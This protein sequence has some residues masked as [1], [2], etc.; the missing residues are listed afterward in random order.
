MKNYP[1]LAYRSGTHMNIIRFFMN[2]GSKEYMIEHIGWPTVPRIGDRII[3]STI[4]VTND[5]LPT[6]KVS[7]VVWDVHN[8][9][10]RALVFCQKI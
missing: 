8:G 2:I 5:A 10:A 4:F 6:A 1:S 7:D 3:S 9:K